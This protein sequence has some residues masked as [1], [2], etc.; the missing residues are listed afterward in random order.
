LRHVERQRIALALKRSAL[1][2]RRQILLAAKALAARHCLVDRLED[3]V[4]REVR[5]LDGVNQ[6][7]VWAFAGGDRNLQLRI[8]LGPR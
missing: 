5:D 4:V 7:E 3:A 2:R 6:R 1:P 8:E